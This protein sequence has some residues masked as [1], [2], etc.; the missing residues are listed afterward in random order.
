MQVIYTGRVQ[1][2][3]FRYMVKSLARGFDVAGT[4]KNLA[5]GQVELISEG[6]KDE[7]AAFQKAIRE[8]ELGH[9]I[10]REDVQWLEAQGG[11]KGFEI[12]K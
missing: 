5:G 10:Q 7:L 4:V 9:H 6:V 12:I 3:G 1:G 11:L 2:I 8:S